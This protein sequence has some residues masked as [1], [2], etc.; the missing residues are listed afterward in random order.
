MRVGQ[1]GCYAIECVVDGGCGGSVPVA[2]CH[3][4]EHAAPLVASREEAVAQID[5]V[6]VAPAL[7]AADVI[8]AVADGT[9]I[10]GVADVKRRIQGVAHYTTAMVIAVDGCGDGDIGSHLAALD[11][12]GHTGVATGKAHKAGSM[13]RTIDTTCCDEFPDRSA[14][15]FAEGRSALCRG[16]GNI[17]GQRMVVSVKGAHKLMVAAASRAGDADV[18]SQLHRLAAE[19]VP[20]VVFL[21]AVAEVFPAFRIADEV[22]ILLRSVAISQI[23]CYHL[24]CCDGPNKLICDSRYFF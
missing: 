13:Q 16:I 20:H 10:D 5:G 17:D 2:D 22:R 15:D 21:Q 1:S 8:A 19:A 9:A 7:E 12:I 14:T 11:G 23:V 3:G 4:V 24:S 6:A 18:S